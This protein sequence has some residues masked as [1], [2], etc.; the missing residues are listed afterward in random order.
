MPSALGEPK[1]SGSLEVPG[2]STLQS[3]PGHA[4]LATWINPIS[5]EEKRKGRKKEGERY[6][7]HKSH[8]PTPPPPL[9]KTAINCWRKEALFLQLTEGCTENFR[10]AAIMS[11]H[12]F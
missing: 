11:S 6:K 12:L 5:K 9:L 4:G 1:A 7:V 10:N 8:L 3:T 2:Q